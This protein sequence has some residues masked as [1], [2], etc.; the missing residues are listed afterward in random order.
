VN[1]REKMVGLPALAARAKSSAESGAKFVVASGSFD[2][3]SREIVKQLE[4]A[5]NGNI[6]LIA[7]VE[8]KT[9]P[10][11]LLPAEARA[12]LAAGLASVDHVVIANAREVEDVLGAAEMLEVKSDLAPRLLARFR[13][14]ARA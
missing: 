2:L 11:C 3:L 14:P 13:G 9:G 7:A 4:S 6:V 12:Q 1:T 5:R 10:G 8:P